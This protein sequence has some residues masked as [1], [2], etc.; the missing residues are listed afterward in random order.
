M[1]L[2][3]DPQRDKSKLESAARVRLAALALALLAAAAYLLVA[4]R[5]AV[6]FPYW[7]DYYA[8]LESLGKVRA[9]E[10]VT[11]KVAA[12]FSQHNEHRVAW[13]RA[14]ALACCAVQGRV[15]FRTLIWL[16]NAGLIALAVI[17]VAGA[18]RSVRWP[19]LL[20][21]IPLALLSPI[22]GKQM[23]WATAAL[24]NYWVLTFAAAALLLLSRGSRATF[25]WAC[26]LAVLATFSSGQ[27]LLCFPAG[28]VLL[29]VERRWSRALSWLAVMGLSA[30][31]YFHNFTRPPYHPAPQISWTAVQF[32]P[33]AVG[34]AVSD[35]ACR[36]LAPALA[37]PLWEAALVPTI[38]AAAGLALIG[39]TAW[40]W[41]R[42][43][44]QRNPFVSVFLLYLLLLFAAASV[45]RSGLGLQHALMSHYKVISVSI[46]VLVAVG[47]LDQR[48]PGLGEPFPQAAVL[49]G[50]TFFC[51]LS[52]CLY[53][54]GVK[55]F[56]ANLAEGRR[57]FVQ[58]QDSRGVMSPPQGQPA[59]DILWRSYLTGLLRLADLDT[60]Q[61]IRLS[62]E[63]LSRIATPCAPL[64]SS[65]LLPE[66]RLVAKLHWTGDDLLLVPES[67]SGEAPGATGRLL[68]KRGK[69]QYVPPAGAPLAPN[70]PQ[71]GH[72]Y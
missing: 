49:L 17:L 36:A 26:V 9:S 71:A 11:E 61:G 66:G 48:Y 41:V 69:L 44:Y 33:T 28:A 1:A 18:R 59:L 47:L 65:T 8:V 43:Y 13:L 6:D 31:V 21:L 14:I 72:G 2:M 55:A 4:G 68:L 29:V 32:F 42:R 35:L 45:S 60:T 12:V 5:L 56:S 19:S 38:Q 7:D 54:P 46:V 51:L 50:G 58:S 52:W 30:V 22:Q 16:G 67:I 10:T 3:N 57:W 63:R 15:D 27:G 24:G 62:P 25:S 37:H 40:L 70:N 39:L 23:I 53:Y 20:A 34:S 64:L